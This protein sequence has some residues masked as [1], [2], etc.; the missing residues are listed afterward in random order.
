M[1]NNPR[2]PISSAVKTAIRQSFVV[3]FGV[4]C[5]ATFGQPPTAP[6]LSA[7]I[8]QQIDQYHR[9]SEEQQNPLRVIYFHPQDV[10]PQKDHRQ[11]LTRILLDVQAFYRDEMNRLGFGK[12]TFPLELEEQNLVLHMVKGRRASDGYTHESGN[13]VR[14]EISADVQKQMNL[15]EEFV[16]SINAMCTKREDGSYFFYAPYY[17][18]GNAKQG[19]CHAADCEVMDTL[20]YTE[21]EKR[22]RYEEHYGQRDQ[23]LAQFSCLYIG[24]IAHELGHAFG[25]PHNREKPWEKNQLGTA[26][27]GSGNYTFR[28]EKRGRQGSFLTYATAVQLA[29]QPLFTGSRRGL[30]VDLKCELADVEFKQEKLTMVLRGRIDANVPPYAVVAYTNPKIH[31][32]WQNKD[33][34]ALTWISGIEQGTFEIRARVHPPGRSGLKLRVCHLNGMKTDFKFEFDVNDQ[35]V[36]QVQPLNDQWRIQQV[37][38]AFLNGD[39]RRATKLAKNALD[40]DASKITQ[41]KLR[42]VLQLAHPEPP[43]DLE[44]V[45]EDEAYLSDLKWKSANVGWGVP[46]QN[47]YCIT[48]TI[49]DALFLESASGQFF[50]HG[51]YAHAPSRY[52]FDLNGQ[53]RR[54]T[55]VAAL[56]KGV[57]SVGTGVFRVL[58]DEKVLY[59]SKRLQGTDA[60]AIDID[61]TG[62]QSL[63][64]IIESGKRGNAGCW[65][66]WGDAKIRR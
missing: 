38:Q 25:I 47:Q 49:K 21:T 35:G 46:T 10:A 23:S 3:L 50:P 30:D 20:N 5:T 13:Q 54:F 17:G 45:E 6:N 24:G 36:P 40:A 60:E 42:H 56:Q 66:I 33:Y 27:M 9:D 32:G 7:Q 51:F 14:R 52:S 31:E 48:R 58:G 55:A 11:R 2:T 61:I 57:H 37:E 64:L 34:D 62:V 1:L 8:R 19:L 65:T 22:I 12:R 39:V 4:C 16:L 44:V 41:A 26:L 29:S 63:D 28:H 59:E 15:Q 18:S 53:W 43:Q